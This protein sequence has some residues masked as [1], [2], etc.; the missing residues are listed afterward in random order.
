MA[1]KYIYIYIY[2][3]ILY[4]KLNKNR[5][6]IKPHFRNFRVLALSLTMSF[7]LPGSSLAISE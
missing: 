7:D 1:D 4:Y 6:G 3:Y 5:L 2:I